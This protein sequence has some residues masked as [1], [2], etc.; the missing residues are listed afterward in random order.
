MAWEFLIDVLHLP[1][2]KLFVSYFHGDDKLGLPADVECKR[3]WLSLGYVMFII[4]NLSIR[5]SA[6]ASSVSLLIWWGKPASWYKITCMYCGC[7][8]HNAHIV[9]GST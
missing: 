3:V 8:H 4:I 5:L 2:E 6:L 7:M 1:Q 9:F